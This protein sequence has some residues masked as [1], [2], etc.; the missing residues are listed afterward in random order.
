M[1]RFALTFISGIILVWFLVNQFQPSASNN[2]GGRRGP[3]GAMAVAVE[4][5]PLKIGS[6]VDEGRFVGS[7][8]ATSKFMVAPKSR[9]ASRNCL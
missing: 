4:T 2:A 5:E 9:A 7:I 6:L 1:N 3:G 8:E